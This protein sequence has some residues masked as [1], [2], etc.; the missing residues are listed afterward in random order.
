MTSFSSVSMNAA[1]HKRWLTLAQSLN[2]RGDPNVIWKELHT[3]YS[4][5]VR[6]YHNL[7]HITACLR[8]FDAVPK[9]GLDATAV[10]LAIWFH[11]VIY[12]P[13]AKDNEAQSAELFAT[14]VRE[15]G[16][17]AELIAR[18]KGLILI[19]QHKALPQ[20]PEEQLL[21][22][23]DLS[24]LGAEE[25]AFAEYERQIRQ[26]Y[27]WVPEQ[28]FCTGRAAVLGQFLRRKRIFHTLHFYQGFEAAARENL[29]QAIRRWQ[30]AM[31]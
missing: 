13:Q 17:E 14:L 10:E 4:E 24:I 27:G 9:E 8:A 28:E 29:E 19:T 7:Q 31:Q 18:V 6:A 2:W 12:D 1:L 23:V 25:D 15:A 30:G 3:R 22:D 11:D 16:L 20:T 21:V 26:E 5:P